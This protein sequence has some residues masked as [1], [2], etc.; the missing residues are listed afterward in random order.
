MSAFIICLVFFICDAGAHLYIQKKV[1]KG[2][3]EPMGGAVTKV[4]L[5]PSLY[6]A[7]H[8]ASLAFGR[9]L[10]SGHL[11]LLIAVFYTLGDMMLI[12]RQ[13]I[14]FYLGVVYFMVGHCLYIAYFSHFG[15]SWL[16]M[17][18]GLAV[19]GTLYALYCRKILE[20][21]PPL[22][23][24]YLVYGLM[25]L[26]FAVGMAGVFSSQHIYS[27]LTALVG[28]VLFGWSDCRIAYNIT[29]VRKTGDAAIMLTYI[30]ANVFLACAVY[31]IN[32]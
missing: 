14:C 19:F 18:L 2:G 15:F 27:S 30:L 20:R 9:D 4:L 17:L 26:V 29:G 7:L 10:A 31:C 8:L 21:K 22:V 25:I 23:A 12:F 1:K 3:P 32:V 5:M 6:L 24:G 16:A 11:V 13:S 28:V